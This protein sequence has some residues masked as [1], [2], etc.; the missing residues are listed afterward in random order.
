MIW[1]NGIE[2]CIISYM[3]RVTSSGSMHDTGCL[4]LVHWDC[5]PQG[6]GCGQKAPRKKKKILNRDQETLYEEDVAQSGVRVFEKQSR[7]HRERVESKEQRNPEHEG[8]LT[9]CRGDGRSY[10]G[11]VEY[12][13]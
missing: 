6:V 11:P 13:N 5:E 12:Y 2:I 7:I 3:K 4:G 10:Q 9:T 8:F 1:E